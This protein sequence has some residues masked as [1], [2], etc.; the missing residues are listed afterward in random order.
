MDRAGRLLRGSRAWCLLLSRLSH[1]F[2]AQ[3]DFHHLNS[4]L[5]SDPLTPHDDDPAVTYDSG[6]FCADDWVLTPTP[7]NKRM[8]KLKVNRSRMNPAHLIAPADV[9]LPLIAPGDSANA[10]HGGKGRGPGG[11]TRCGACGH[12]ADRGSGLARLKPGRAAKNVRFSNRRISSP[13]VSFGPRFGRSDVL[14]GVFG[15]RG[16]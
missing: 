2:Y 6:F 9:V 13:S 3:A 14:N 12:L 11:E 1:A 5:M 4:S 16:C 10:E 8:A 15:L 7:T